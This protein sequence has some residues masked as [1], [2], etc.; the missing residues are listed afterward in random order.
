MTKTPIVREED[1]I[2]EFDDFSQN[3]FLSSNIQIF[4]EEKFENWNYLSLKDLLITKAHN[5]LNLN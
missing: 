2:F 4:V 5:F 3:V 1:S